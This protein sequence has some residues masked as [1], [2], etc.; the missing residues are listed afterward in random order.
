[1]RHVAGWRPCWA[2]SM[3]R[4][5]SPEAASAIERGQVIEAIRQVRADTGLGLAEAKALV[6]SYQSG[7]ASV[8]PDRAVPPSRADA[9]L[10]PAAEEALRR[11]RVIDAIKMVRKAEGIDL[12]QAKARVDARRGASAGQAAGVGF[13]G[14]AERRSPLLMVFILVM[15]LLLA[16]YVLLS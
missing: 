1:M 4:R 7:E 8:G 10:P 3:R 15:I 6:D 9:P 14:P 2:D 13:A 12:K 16:W 5:I 11:G